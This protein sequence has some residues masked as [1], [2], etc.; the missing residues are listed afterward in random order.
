[1]KSKD[2]WQEILG[3]LQEAIAEFNS[4]L[5]RQGARHTLSSGVDALDAIVHGLAAG[6]EHGAQILR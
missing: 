4:N 3:E 1:M 5:V 2:P 6:G